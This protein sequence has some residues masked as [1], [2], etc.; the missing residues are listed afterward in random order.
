MRTSFLVSGRSTGFDGAF[1]WYVR[2][3][4]PGLV[5]RAGLGT[6]ALSHGMT[7]SFR[8]VWWLEPPRCCQHPGGLLHCC[9]ARTS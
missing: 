6:F 2:F 3:V 4:R 1:R 5:L 8:V 9:R 7:L